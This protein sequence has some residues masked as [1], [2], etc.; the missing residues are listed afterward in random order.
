M[1]K[2][3]KIIWFMADLV[4]VVFTDV[5]FIKETKAKPIAGI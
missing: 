1:Q 3:K 4:S 2:L 5:S